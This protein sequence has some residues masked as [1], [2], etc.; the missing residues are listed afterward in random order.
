MLHGFIDSDELSASALR[1]EVRLS[2][3]IKII[4]NIEG[5]TAIKD[6]SVADDNKETAEPDPWLICV[7]DGKKPVAAS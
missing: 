6:I 3:L 1:T 4:M 2:D 5:V 7:E